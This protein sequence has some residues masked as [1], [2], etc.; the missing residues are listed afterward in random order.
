M[1]SVKIGIIPLG[2]E[3]NFF[4]QYFPDQSRML[5]ARSANNTKITKFNGSFL[6]RMIGEATRT[7]IE[8]NSHPLSIMKL[9]TQEGNTI[10]ALQQAR[11]GIP[12][13]A[14]KKKD[15]FVMHISIFFIYIILKFLVTWTT[16]HTCFAHLYSC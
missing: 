11:W 10:Y 4:K 15:R 2:K 7:I 3:N 6:F 12:K 14:Y 13:D 5:M 16:A 9:C 1:H 8:G